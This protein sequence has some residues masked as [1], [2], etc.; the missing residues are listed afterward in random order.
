M[1]YG[2]HGDSGPAPQ[3]TLEFMLEEQATEEQPVCA[4][5]GAVESEQAQVVIAG[6]PD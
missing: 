3:E 5:D 4:V 2:A 6:A 1:P